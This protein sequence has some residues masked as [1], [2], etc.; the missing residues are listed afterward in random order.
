MQKKKYRIIDEIELKC[1]LEDSHRLACLEADGVDDWTW[2]MEGRDAYIAKR[3]VNTEPFKDKD[4]EEIIEIVYE[5]DIGFDTLAEIDLEAYA[6][7]KEVKTLSEDKMRFLQDSLSG[8][9]AHEPIV[10]MDKNGNP[11]WGGF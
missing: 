11:K 3:L 1:L 8:Q 2:Y 9:E 7:L 5:G 4:L 6:E 10:E